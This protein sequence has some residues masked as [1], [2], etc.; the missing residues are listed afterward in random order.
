M[1]TSALKKAAILT[2]LGAAMGLSSPPAALAQGTI[3]I[4][5]NHPVE[6]RNSIFAIRYGADGNLWPLRLTEYPTGGTGT[7]E[8]LAGPPEGVLDGDQQVIMNPQ[9]TLLFAVNQGSD[10]IAVFRV[11]TGGDLRPVPGSPFPSGG[12]APTSLAL[13]GD[14]LVVVN[15]AKDP[16]REGIDEMTPNHTVHRVGADGTLTPV[17]GSTVPLPKDSNPTQ[18]LL[19]PDG[20]FVFDAL[21]GGR[22]LTAQRLEAGGTL[23]PTPTPSIELDPAS[24]EGAAVPGGL[25]EDV[26][27]IPLGLAHHPTEP[28]FYVNAVVSNYLATYS[29]D[30]RG[31]LRFESAVEN[32]GAF[33]PC[34]IVI[35]RD[36]SRL[37]TAN[38]YTDTVSVFDIERDPRRPRQIQTVALKRAGTPSELAIDPS[39]RFLFVITPRNQANVAP[40]EGNTLHSLRIDSDG[41]LRELAD[42]PIPLPVLPGTSPQGITVLA[43]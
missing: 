37:Y 21:F 15:K 33:L 39:G 10:S 4:E 42:S 11:S 6:E 38:T 8:V 30:Q 12:P 27:K 5:S 31:A 23:A 34:W 26:L 18:A 36:G 13:S 7:V 16:L 40:G 20:Q 1:P 24:R 25:S 3:F 28:L 43:D 17:R 9:R 19:S 22:R 14:T 32:E 35:S 29:Y 2:G 41:R